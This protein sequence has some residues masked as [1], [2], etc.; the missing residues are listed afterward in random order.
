MLGKAA[1]IVNRCRLK[2]SGMLWTVEGAD[3]IIALRSPL[4]SNRVDEYW[5]DRAAA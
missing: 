4:L 3:S 1:Q 5:E 2:C